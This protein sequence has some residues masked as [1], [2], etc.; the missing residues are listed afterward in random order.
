MYL[1]KQ[2]KILFIWYQGYSHVTRD[3][4]M[5]TKGIY[6]ETNKTAK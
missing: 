1:A 4:K 2:Q 3:N 5:E 6:Q